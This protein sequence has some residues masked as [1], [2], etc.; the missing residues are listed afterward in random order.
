MMKCSFLV[1]FTVIAG[2]FLSGCGASEF[3][4]DR[5][6]LKDQIVDDS[7]VTIKFKVG[8]PI[9]LQSFDESS[10]HVWGDKTGLVK[11]NLKYYKT[12]GDVTA[13][14]LDSLKRDEYVGVVIT[15]DVR[16]STGKR[17]PKGAAWSFWV[18]FQSWQIRPGKADSNLVRIDVEDLPEPIGGIAA[19]QNATFYPSMALQNGIQGTVYTEAYVDEDGTV[20]KTVLIRGIGGGC[21]EAA[22]E[23]IQHTKFRPGRVHGKPVKVRMVIPI[24]FRLNR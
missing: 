7:V 3:I 12:T 19:I 11:V 22:A 16:L 14:I 10:F 1:P 21:D 20:V 6:P 13:T 2:L 8:Q 5:Y 23:A 15:D 9:D 18:D 4:T 17:I 24:R